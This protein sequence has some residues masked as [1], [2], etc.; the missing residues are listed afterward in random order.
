M[1]VATVKRRNEICRERVGIWTAVVRVLIVNLVFE[2]RDGALLARQEVHIRC[3]DVGLISPG[4]RGIV[5]KPGSDA[6]NIE[7]RANYINRFSKVKSD[8]RI[9]RRI[10]PLLRGSLPN[11]AGPISTIGAVRR[12]FGTAVTKSS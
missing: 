3:D 12:G 5:M 4:E 2:D 11:T 6:V 10:E 7:P 1:P 9:A 8:T